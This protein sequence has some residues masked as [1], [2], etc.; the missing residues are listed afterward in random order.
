MAKTDEGHKLT[1]KELSKLERRI[2]KL[3]RE[4]GK[5]LQGTIDA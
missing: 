3:Y 5:E 2:T 4:A 1:D